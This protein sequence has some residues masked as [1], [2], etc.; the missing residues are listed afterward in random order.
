VQSR[1]GLASARPGI[2]EA[3]YLRGNVT[4]GGV[5]GG[6][7]LKQKQEF[8]VLSAL[9]NQKLSWSDLTFGS[10]AAHQRRSHHSLR[11]PQGAADLE[12]SVGGSSAARFISIEKDSGISAKIQAR[13]AAQGRL[14]G[15]C[16]TRSRRARIAVNWSLC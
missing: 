8:A 7:E 2:C 10:I 13:S 3:I 11:N 9:A 15:V 12:V 14:S 4:L 6:E 16:A 1:L 5:G